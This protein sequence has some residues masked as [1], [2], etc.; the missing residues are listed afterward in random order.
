MYTTHTMLATVT[1]TFKKGDVVLQS[2][3][4]V[5]APCGYIQYFERGALFTECLACLAGTEFGPEGYREN[6]EDFWQFLG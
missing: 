6:E 1:Q 5:C 4:Y 3:Q 2:G